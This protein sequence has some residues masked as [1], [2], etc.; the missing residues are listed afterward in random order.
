MLKNVNQYTPWRFRG[1]GDDLVVYAK[2]KELAT[3]PKQTACPKG[4]R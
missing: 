2:L 4:T 1:A 3:P